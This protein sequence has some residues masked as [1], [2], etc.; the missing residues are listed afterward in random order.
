MKKYIG[1]TIIALIEIV[2]IYALAAF[3]AKTSFSSNGKT[4]A[5]IQTV[6]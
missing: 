6:K 3:I 2:V 4:T 1:I 5:G